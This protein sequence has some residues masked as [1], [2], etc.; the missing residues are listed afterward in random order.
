MLTIS[1]SILPLQTSHL[2]PSVPPPFV[3]SFQPLS[4]HFP[5]PSTAFLPNLHCF[6]NISFFYLLS[7]FIVFKKSMSF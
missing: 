6:L 2:A 1:V 5:S 4:R 7:F 3:F